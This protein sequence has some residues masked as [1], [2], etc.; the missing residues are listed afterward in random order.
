MIT[1]KLDELN[2]KKKEV[3]I[4]N[5]NKI[6]EFLANK[7]RVKNNDIQKLLGVSD[8]TVTRYMDELERGGKVKQVGHGSEAYYKKA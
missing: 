8:A 6:L 4:E 7:E 3:V 2:Q 1:G 5:K